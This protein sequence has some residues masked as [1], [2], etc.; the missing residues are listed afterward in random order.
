MRLYLIPISTHRTLVFCKRL[1]IS[2]TERQGLIDK[3]TTRA[4]KLW[5][6]WEKKESGWQKMLVGYGNQA[7][8]R[9]PYEEWGLK[10]V[11][12]LSARKE[13]AEMT[14]SSKVELVFPQRIIPVTRAEGVLRALGTEREAMHRKTL[15]WCCAGMPLTA[16]FAIIPLWVFWFWEGRGWG[17]GWG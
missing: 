17:W 9:I 2:T 6:D 10:S 4:A 3:A 13:E 16:P 12:P 14:G 8:R 5:A 7:L 11:P 15:I 1:N